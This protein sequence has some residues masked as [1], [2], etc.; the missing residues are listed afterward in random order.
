[1]PQLH[2]PWALYNWFVYD[3]WYDFSGSSK[4]RGMYLHSLLSPCHFFWQQNG[5]VLTE[6]LRRSYGNCTVIL[7]SLCNLQDIHTKI[8]RCPC[9]DFAGSIWLSQEPTIIFWAQMTILNLAVSSRSECE[10]RTGIMRSTCNVSTGL[11]FSKFV[12]VRS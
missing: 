5:T 11:R 10:A 6:T 4:L 9:D 12:I 7:Q 1:M 8:A 2:L 3:F